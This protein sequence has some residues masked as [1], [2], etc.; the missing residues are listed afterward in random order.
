M[1]SW[2]L[3]TVFVPRIFAMSQTFDLLILQKNF[4]VRDIKVE[5]HWIR[6]DHSKLVI[7]KVSDESFGT[8]MQAHFF[9]I[10]T[11]QTLL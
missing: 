7:E 9:R 2:H 6:Q 4:P 3:L 10:I 5:K 1:E 8:K 11:I